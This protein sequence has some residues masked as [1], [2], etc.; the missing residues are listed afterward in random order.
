M[1]VLGPQNLHNFSIKDSFFSF[2]LIFLRAHFS[3]RFFKLENISHHQMIANFMLNPTV[4]FLTHF[5]EIL[6]RFFHVK[7]PCASF[8]VK[9]PFLSVIMC[10]IPPYPTFFALFKKVSGFEAEEVSH[11]QN[12]LIMQ[13]IFDRKWPETAGNDRK[14]LRIIGNRLY[15]WKIKLKIYE[16]VF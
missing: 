7:V 15:Q 3:P 10:V 1:I 13:T 14:W 5:S 11:L 9:F 12:D 8:C 2:W 6:A 16:T 4:P